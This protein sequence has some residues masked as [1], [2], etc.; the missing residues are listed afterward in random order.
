MN[1]S[2]FDK[3]FQKYWDKKLKEFIIKHKDKP[4]NNQLAY[5]NKNISWNLFNDEELNELGIFGEESILNVYYRGMSNLWFYLVLYSKVSIPEILDLIL[6]KNIWLNDEVLWRLLSRH[7]DININIILEY[8]DY[9]WNFEELS[10]HE[11]IF[12]KDIK[13]N[14]ELPWCF[15]VMS[16]NPNI[17]YEFVKDNE[18]RSWDYKRLSDN[19]AINFSDIKSDIHKKWDWDRVTR[20]IN[21][22]LEIIDRNPDFP[23][24]YDSMFL[25]KTIRK[26]IIE[27]KFNLHKLKEKYCNNKL[28]LESFEEYFGSNYNI[29]S[30]LYLFSY[31]SNLTFDVIKSTS[32]NWNID[33]ISC[34]E[35]INLEIVKNNPDYNWNMYYLSTNPSITFKDIDN[36]LNLNWCWKNLSQ[37]EFIKQKNL[38][39]LEFIK[40]WFASRRLDRFFF[41]VYYDPIYKMCRN[42][43]LKKHLLVK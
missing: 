33:E 5:L 36:N 17:N 18:F 29:Y 3:Y 11:N 26:Q 4:W 15:S 7:K 12:L 16:Y 8:F 31:D 35:N 34:N 24:I 20:N 10:R 30:R 21:I 32:L 14:I 1:N 27:I 9:P 42:R 43:I 28:L 23:W 22:N 19:P 25:N 37:N 39:R 2:E 38:T 6:K 41:K 40:I 13:D